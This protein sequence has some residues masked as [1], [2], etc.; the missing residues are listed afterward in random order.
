MND[1]NI[2]LLFVYYIMA[3]EPASATLPPE[4][5][6]DAIYKTLKLDTTAYQ[7]GHSIDDIHT[8]YHRVFF[9]N[10]VCSENLLKMLYYGTST[11][12]LLHLMLL[13]RHLNMKEDYDERLK[14]WWENHYKKYNLNFSTLT[15][16]VMNKKVNNDDILSYS[17][18]IIEYNKVLTELTL[19][20]ET[21]TNTNMLKLYYMRLFVISYLLSYSSSGN[22]M[23]IVYAQQ[24]IF[25]FKML[26]ITTEIYELPRVTP[27]NNTGMYSV[28]MDSF[29]IPTYKDNILQI[30]DRKQTGIRKVSDV[31]QLLIGLAD[32][33]S[34]KTRLLPK[35][36][37]LRTG[38]ARF[39]TYSPDETR[40]R[41]IIRRFLSDVLQNDYGIK[42]AKK[43]RDRYDKTCTEYQAVKSTAG[44][45]GSSGA[46]AGVATVPDAGA[47]A[48]AA[49]AAG[50]DDEQ[51]AALKKAHNDDNFI[52]VLKVLTDGK[53]LVGESS[54]TPQKIYSLYHQCVSE[55]TDIWNLVN[56]IFYPLYESEWRDW[57]DGYIFFKLNKSWF[58]F[59]LCIY[60]A[61]TRTDRRIPLPQDTTP[62]PTPAP[63]PTTPPAPVTT[64]VGGKSSRRRKAYKT[65]RR[66]NKTNKNN[67]KHKNKKNYRRKRHTK[68][69]K[70]SHRRRRS[71][72]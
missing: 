6:I 15:K 56:A 48:G 42:C 38:F 9:S 32:I 16:Q 60:A 69:C 13:R 3:S 50:V 49:G 27:I 47:G 21:N 41:C 35:C 37:T 1:Y 44:A 53:V 14:R 68:R 54:M 18:L 5:E 64:A 59:L 57:Y 43:N 22:M 17:V 55:L 71:R 26:N 33:E 23:K 24:V 39:V 51:Y 40:R 61:I 4:L 58:T 7:I 19:N 70:K 28:V 30:M 8:I 63:V 29:L 45:A 65:S 36:F 52:R 10:E 2:F 25:W 20:T 67:N 66:N 46:D 62:A 34:P 12:L 11:P 31:I 72:R